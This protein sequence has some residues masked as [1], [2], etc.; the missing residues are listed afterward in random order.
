MAA[1]ALSIEAG[2]VHDKHDHYH[3]PGSSPGKKAE[4]KAVKLIAHYPKKESTINLEI[5]G[6]VCSFCAY[7]AEKKIGKLDF[8]DKTK[9]GGDGVEVTPE[10]GMARVAIR[11]G[12]AILIPKLFKAV[13]TAGYRLVK[14][15][16]HQEGGVRR[17]KNEYFFTSGFTGQKYLLGN[18]KEVGIKRNIDQIEIWAFFHKKD[19]KDAVGLTVD[20]WEIKK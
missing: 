17:V 9:F 15:Y 2:D 3:A 14:V 5:Q 7:A 12:K 11:Q 19:G 16:L 6:L 1:A 18:A 20:R 4:N 13:E 8:V 10:Q